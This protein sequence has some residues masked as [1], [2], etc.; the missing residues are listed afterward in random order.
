MEVV[1]N[2]EYITYLPCL[3]R[4]AYTSLARRLAYP[5]NSSHSTDQLAGAVFSWRRKTVNVGQPCT[6]QLS[7]A[8]LLPFLV[9]NPDEFLLLIGLCQNPPTSSP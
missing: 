8:H 7:L 4:I 3:D 1:A 6:P 2:R 5:P 9:D